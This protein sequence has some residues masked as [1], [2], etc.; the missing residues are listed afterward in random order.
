[1]RGDASQPPQFWEKSMGDPLAHASM[2]RRWLSYRDRTAV[3]SRSA[4]DGSRRKAIDELVLLVG[5]ELVEDKVFVVVDAVLGLQ[6][7]M[8]PKGERLVGIGHHFDGPG[9]GCRKR[10]VLLDHPSCSVE[11]DAGLT[12]VEAVIVLHPQRSPA[13]MEHDGVA[14]LDVALGHV[15]FLQRCL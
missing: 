8:D 4:L 5:N 3:A 12:A 7:G 13:G 14:R 11:A 10:E 1:G 15:L 6:L 2:R 9:V